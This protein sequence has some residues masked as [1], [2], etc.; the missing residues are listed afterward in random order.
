MF[1]SDP[2]ILLRKSVLVDFKIHFTP[3]M[4][5]LRIL[6]IVMRVLIILRLSFKLL[7]LNLLLYLLLSGTSLLLSAL[8]ASPF[9][10]SVVLETWRLYKFVN[11]KSFERS[12]VLIP[13]NH[14]HM[15]VWA[16]VHDFQYSIDHRLVRRP[17]DSDG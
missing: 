1:P 14:P 2:L 12:H 6:R 13:A 15:H 10:A 4:V 17:L 9:F 5:L 16:S 7:M 8:D 11:R 3:V